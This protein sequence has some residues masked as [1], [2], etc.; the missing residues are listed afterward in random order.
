[1]SSADLVT[2]GEASSSTLI[3]DTS[4]INTTGTYT[5]LCYPHSW[6][7]PVYIHQDNMHKAFSIVRHLM[8]RK[9][10]QVR[11]VK[12]FVDLVDEVYKLL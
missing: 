1:M 5:H 12:Q 7:Y 2:W 4:G 11:T 10:A 9:L 3:T 6:H 8:D